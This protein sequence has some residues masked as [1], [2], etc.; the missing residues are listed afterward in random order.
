MI[1]PGAESKIIDIYIYNESEWKRDRQK[2]R[3]IDR[4]I[5][6]Y[7]NRH[8]WTDPEQT[9]KEKKRYT[10]TGRDKLSMHR[11]RVTVFLFMFRWPH[12]PVSV[13]FG[14]ISRV[15]ESFPFFVLWSPWPSLLIS[16][17][18]QPI[19]NNACPL[20]P[21]FHIGFF[22]PRLSF[23]IDTHVPTR[24]YMHVQVSFSLTHTH[25]HTWCNV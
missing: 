25:T 5:G 23:S 11:H 24:G 9:K 21:T 2:N 22:H 3:R 7:F 13:R 17:I 10:Y 8:L 18:H 16:I 19:F 4:Q 20:P 1:K 14:Y 6:A 12:F 15:F